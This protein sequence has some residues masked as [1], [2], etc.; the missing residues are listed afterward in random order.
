M[1]KMLKAVTYGSRD[2]KITTSIIESI[3]SNLGRQLSNEVRILLDKELKFKEVKDEKRGLT[4]YSSEIV[5]MDRET[6]EKLTFGKSPVN[7]EM[8][9]R[10]E[11]TTMSSLYGEMG[12]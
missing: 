3:K 5:L 4:V 11:K 6:Y 8:S 7:D 1:E 12:K 10:I 9:K 2:S